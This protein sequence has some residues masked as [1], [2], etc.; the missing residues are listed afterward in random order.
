LK[1]AFN[2]G[3][4]NSCRTLSSIFENMQHFCVRKLSAVT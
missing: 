2:E 1:N 4:Q 3:G